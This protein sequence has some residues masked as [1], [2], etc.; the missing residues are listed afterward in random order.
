MGM[1]AKQRATTALRGQTALSPDEVMEI[2]RS[3]T[4]AVKGGGGSLLTTGITN[5][6]ARVNI[7][8]DHASS[9]T[10]S[11][12]SGK[13]L[14]ELCTFDAQANRMGDRTGVVIGGLD[15]YKTQQSK[16]LYFIPAGPKKIYGMAPYKKFLAAIAD[17]LRR[18]DASASIEIAQAGG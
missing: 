1:T 9:M 4:N 8:K 2:V 7:V 10:L 14:V 5:L 16:L 12:T 18:R 15:T 13:Q 11:L 3:T 17:E 6:G